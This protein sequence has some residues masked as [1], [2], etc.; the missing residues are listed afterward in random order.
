ME[1]FTHRK[2]CSNNKYVVEWNLRL[3]DISLIHQG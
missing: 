1:K 2:K 3:E